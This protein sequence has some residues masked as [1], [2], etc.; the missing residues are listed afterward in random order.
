MQAQEFNLEV[1][2]ILPKALERL[3]DL[4]NDL[5][6]SWNVPTRMLFERLD[7]ELWS[8]VGHNP[9]LFLRNI[10]Q[11]RLHKVA[12]EPSFLSAYQQ[13]LSTYDA[14]CHSKERRNG[15]KQLPQYALIAY[16]CAEY[17]FHESMPVYSGGLGILA[18]DHCKTASNMRLPFIAVGLFYHKGYFNQ[19]IDAQGNQISTHNVNNSQDLPISPVRDEAGEEIYIEVKIAET[20]V[21]VKAWLITVGHIKLY[22]L[23]TNV[24]QNNDNDRAITHQLYGGDEH[25]RIRQE[26]V[27]GIGGTRLLRRLGLAPTIW[28]INEGHA[29]FMILERVRELITSGQ[30]F[31]TAMEA[32]AA[33][34]VFTTHTPVPAGHDKFPQELM[35]N[36]LGSFCE[37]DLRLSKE[38]FLALGCWPGDSPDFNMTTLAIQGARHLNGVSR[39]HGQVSSKI[40]AKFW[41]EISPAENPI[42]YVTNGVHVP[43]MLARQWC[44]LFKESFVEEW[45]DHQHDATFWQQIETIPDPQFWKVKQTVKSRMLK[46]I[47]KSLTAQHLRHQISETHLERLLKY[48][49][50]KN[51]NILTIGFA[52]RFAT[53]KR[54][55]LLFKDMDKLRSIMTDAERPVVF[56]FA[57]KAHPADMPGQDMLKE[58]YQISCEPEFIGKILVVQGYDLGLSRRLL[59]GVD[60]WLNNPIYPLEASGT[61]GMKAGINGG[62]NLSVLDGW[63]PESYDGSNGWAIKPSPHQDENLRDHNDAR[64]L[65]EVLIDEVIPLYYNRNQKDYSE[66]WVKKAKRSMMTILPRFNTIRML[67]DYITNLYLPAS[68]KG[69]QLNSHNY[70]KAQE[71]ANWK[72]LIKA[73]WAE[74]QARLLSAPQMQQFSYGEPITIQ[75]ALR[76]NGLEPNSV[77][78]E[79]LLSRKVYHPEILL[80]TQQEL[81]NIW[82]SD[83]TNTVSY[84]FVPEQPLHD[85]SEYLYSLTFQPDLCGGLSYQIRVF[86]FH[87]LLS[88]AYEMGMMRWV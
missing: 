4:A 57:G 72:T 34:T 81:Q 37:H 83:K 31:E 41:P 40:C 62:I 52:R 29:A 39:I 65:Y 82:Q 66:G 21:F 69:V 46:V 77:A 49:D 79:L 60:V 24:P 75:V 63:W 10:D 12:T 80:P 23:D 88:D 84:K 64:S 18:G 54:A 19:F 11:R 26:I 30:D 85:S 45:F 16:F 55:T 2:P 87:D 51:P 33:N 36:Y 35:M 13:V 9:K 58:I 48:V 22:L 27:L 17:G 7:D 6:Y 76:L 86:P 47:C 1:I 44:E 43:S 50:P 78:V 61:S 68:H 15:G 73:K 42:G 32:V 28:H 53:Y 74:V 38:T 59:S 14:Y 5:W 8:R 71:L 70:A 56:I 25:T 20:Q 67:N 3:E